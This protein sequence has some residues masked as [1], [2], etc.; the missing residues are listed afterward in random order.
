MT[1]NPSDELNHLTVSIIGPGALGR[2]LMTDL[3][4]NGYRIR[5]VFSRNPENTIRISGSPVDLLTLPEAT[6]DNMG[7]LLFI[8]APDNQIAD[9]AENLSGM[10]IRWSER[11]AVHCSGLLTSEE[12]TPLERAGA[13][14]ASFHPLQTFTKNPVSGKF[15]DIYISLEGTPAAIQLLQ[16]VVSALHAKPVLLNQKQKSLLHVSAVYLSNYLVTLCDIADDL[17]RSAIP[18]E[19]LD[20]I[21]PLLLETA[22]NLAQNSPEEALTG[23]VSRG[24]T[25]TIRKHL[26]LLQDNLEILNTY[27]A[28]GRHTL[29]IVKKKGT[30]P[31][32]VILEMNSMFGDT[33]G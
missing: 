23:P 2:S 30:L 14:T 15:R 20:L 4:D 22:H 27:K 31:D 9:I 25:L 8:T 29:S 10:D 33:T 18:G 32:S 12:L 17:I 16:G 1:E 7:D 19:N 11:T 24:D 6:R 26:L 13:H 21:R 28:L 5:S 3:S